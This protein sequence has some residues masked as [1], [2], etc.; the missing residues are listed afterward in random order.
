MMKATLYWMPMWCIECYIIAFTA[1]FASATPLDYVFGEPH[2]QLFT[3]RARPQECVG[4]IVVCRVTSREI[5][6]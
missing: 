3:P 5:A 1:T 2:G 6:L 4:D